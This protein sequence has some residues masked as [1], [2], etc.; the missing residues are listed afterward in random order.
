[1]TPAGAV[2]WFWWRLP[3]RRVAPIDLLEDPAQLPELVRQA[4][5]LRSVAFS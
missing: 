3:G 1:L 2:E 5:S 4:A